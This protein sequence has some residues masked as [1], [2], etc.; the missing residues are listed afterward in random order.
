MP[1]S[2]MHAFSSD[3]AWIILGRM[4]SIICFALWQ[5]RMCG[6]IPMVYCAEGVA[7]H[8]HL[9]I[10]ETFSNIYSKAG[11]VSKKDEKD[12]AEYAFLGVGVLVR[13]RFSYYPRIIIIITHIGASSLVGRE[14]R[15]RNHRSLSEAKVADGQ[16]SSLLWN[17]SLLVQR[18]K[19]T[20][21]S[22]TSWKI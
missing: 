2:T 5:E 12:F 13:I 1:P 14:L 15:G 8:R 6:Y 16:V 18:S 11:E 9:S 19:N 22:T 10:A 7:F 4:R 21:P 17:Q 20:K 3:G